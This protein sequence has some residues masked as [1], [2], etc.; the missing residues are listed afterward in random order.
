MNTKVLYEFMD[1]RNKFKDKI[2]TISFFNLGLFQR[3]M[4]QF[5]FKVI[6]TPFRFNVYKGQDACEVS[7]SININ[8]FKFS[9]RMIP[10]NSG[11]S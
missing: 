8:D 5:F 1:C 3:S 2:S 11:L 7:L 10:K 6:K 4:V 9:S